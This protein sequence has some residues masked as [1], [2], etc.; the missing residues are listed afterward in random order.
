METEQH[1]MG[2][3]W[4][5]GWSDKDHKAHRTGGVW[6]TTQGVLGSP[7]DSYMGFPTPCNSPPSPPQPTPTK[8]EIWCYVGLTPPEYGAV[9]G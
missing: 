2:T 4:E 7:V 9:G 6:T 8:Y 1:K 3:H 5:P